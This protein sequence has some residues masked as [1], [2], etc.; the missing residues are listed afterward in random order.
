M[1]KL[2]DIPKKNI[3]EV[4]DG[5][6]DRLPMQIHSKVEGASVAH[7]YPVWS[8]VLRFALPVVI[9][10][11]ALT[12]YLKPKSFQET[13]ELLATISNEHLIAYLHE[14]DISEN[15]I[16]D[17]ANFDNVDADSLNLKVQS[18]YPLTQS[19]E[20]EVKSELENEL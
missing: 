9:A 8:L 1:K 15:E 16:L 6:F 12:Y 14:T 7:S 13:E 5:Y 18:T 4:P 11:L 10:G 2:E 17:I 19:I 3:F 20:K